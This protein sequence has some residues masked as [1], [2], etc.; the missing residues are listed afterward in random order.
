MRLF[1]Q[2]SAGVLFALLLG[3]LLL[4]SF[5]ASSTQGRLL[6]RGGIGESFQ[7]A[8]KVV[9]CP[10]VVEKFLLGNEPVVV[11]GIDADL[12]SSA[13]PELKSRLEEDCRK[14]ANTRLSWA[15]GIVATLAVGAFVIAWV[16]RAD[17]SAGAA[18][19]GIERNV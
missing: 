7:V 8:A 13:L 2:V 10:S 3:V 6:D 12:R 9:E 18:L 11:Q 19:R 17:E 4:D 14:G 16:K 15:G 5:P 1:V